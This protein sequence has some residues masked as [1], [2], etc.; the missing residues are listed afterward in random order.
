MRGSGI[1]SSAPR[2][3]LSGW[4]CKCLGQGPETSVAQAQQRF[5]SDP[6]EV[7]VPSRSLRNGFCLSPLLA[8]SGSVCRNAL[9]SLLPSSPQ[10]GTLPLD[11]T[12]PGAALISA[13]KTPGPCPAC[14]APPGILRGMPSF[15]APPARGAPHQTQGATAQLGARLLSC[16]MYKGCL[17]ISSLGLLVLFIFFPT[18]THAWSPPLLLFSDGPE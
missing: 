2:P 15:G 11:V 17:Y 1:P 6:T 3:T 18:H 5:V 10:G 16:M 14:A 7:L 9:Q 8:G 12:Q 13:A 4:E